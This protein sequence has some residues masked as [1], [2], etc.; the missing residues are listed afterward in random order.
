MLKLRG[1]FGE[2]DNIAHVNKQMSFS[3]TIS[4]LTDRGFDLRSDQTELA[5]PLVPWW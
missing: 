3:V 4:G 2:L 1:T 5:K